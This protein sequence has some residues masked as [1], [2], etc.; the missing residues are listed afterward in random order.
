ML[1]LN[2]PEAVSDAATRLAGRVLV[3]EQVAP[4]LEVFCGMARDPV[5]GPVYALGR[6]GTQVESTTPVTFVGPLTPE[7]VRLMISQAGLET[8][9]SPLAVA[10]LAMDALA[11]GAPRIGEIDINPIVCAPDGAA[12]AVDALIVLTA[13]TSPD[14]DSP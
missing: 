2:G 6:G 11:R 14:E 5:W 3:A 7:L 13:D 12:R 8:W 10:L 9:Q 1:N 4:G